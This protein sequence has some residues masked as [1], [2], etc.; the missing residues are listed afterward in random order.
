M[1]GK[2]PSTLGEILGKVMGERGL[3]RGSLTAKLLAVWDAAVG[4]G[5][6]KHALPES[7][8]G[9]VLTVI[10]DSPVWMH[11]LS[12]MAPALVEK[13]NT[14]M[15]TGTVQDI[16]F[17]AGRL[18][19]PTEGKVE[20]ERFVPKRRKLLPDERRE[21]EESVSMISDKELREKA[22]RLLESSCTREKA[23]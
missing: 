19:R 20:K 14:V 22:R 21:I 16:R 15:G 2:A 10:V 7:V 1:A 3:G 11:Q 23:K 13:V 17:R 18:V 5:I 4:E 8:K 9:G 12:M 6:A